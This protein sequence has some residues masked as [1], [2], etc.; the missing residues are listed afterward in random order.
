MRIAS[1]PLDAIVAALEL[2]KQQ[3]NTSLL[4]ISSGSRI[5]TP[6]D[7]PVGAAGVLQDSFQKSA[8]VQFA[9]NNAALQGQLQVA[10]STLSSV[11]SALTRV[12]T[13]GTQGA[14]GTLSDSNRQA[15]AQE[16][17]GIKD[18]LTGLG[19][20]QFQG[21]YL[22]AGTNTRSPAFVADPTAPGGVRY[23]GN[24]NINSVQIASG[25]FTPTNVPGSKIFRGAG[26]DVFSSVNDLVNA[27]NTG[28]GI[29]TA[30]AA[31]QKAFDYVNTQRSFYG[32]T[33]SRVNSTQT[34]LSSEQLQLAQHTTTISGADLAQASSNLLQAQTEQQAL[35]GA[36]SKVN[37]G[38]L[39]NILQ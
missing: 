32:T 4:Q 29:D 39:I 34:F 38:G 36:A 16:V 18:Q 2:N 10:D 9:S 20:V 31:V 33:L 5:N 23:D 13:L 30:T 19:N 27:L 8:D 1:N 26:A 3:Q 14:N 24:T 37:Q 12:V 25:Q 22:F 7:D 28:T 35:V 6:S 21:N 11:I 17:S 15:I